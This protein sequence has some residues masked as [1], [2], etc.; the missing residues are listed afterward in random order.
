[1]TSY[2]SVLTITAFT[3]ERY[4][5]ICHP[6]KAHK[7]ANLSRSVKIL[8]AIWTT[9]LL[10]ALPYPLHTELFYYID[11]EHNN[12]TQ[13]EESLICNIPQKY[14]GTMMYIFQ[15]STFLF[16]V[17]PM[18]V[19]AVLYFLIAISLRHAALQRVASQETKLQAGTPITQS[20]KSV[21]RMLGKLSMYYGFSGRGM[22]CD[23][24]QKEILIPMWT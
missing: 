23:I 10:C 18:T 8:I 14:H 16:F 5:A 12:G 13:I 9:S 7:F 20:G 3:V 22:L 21:F 4:V 17:F 19:I 2:A 11:A 1:M 15:F 24:L 6:L